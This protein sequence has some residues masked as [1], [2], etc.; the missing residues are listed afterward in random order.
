MAAVG[1]AYIER[2][3]IAHVI[4]YMRKDLAFDTASLGY[5][6]S[7]FGW[8]YVVA[9]PLS[10][11]I[12]TRVGHR[13]VL[14]VSALIWC[15]PGDI[16][17]RPAMVAHV[18]GYLNAIAN[19]G[20]IISPVAVGYVLVQPGGHAHALISMGVASVPAIISFSIAYSIL[21]VHTISRA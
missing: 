10:G 13:R 5:V 12:V 18:S 21:K 19:L 15:V 20:T 8:G 4:P 16:S 6:L 11:F 14:A 9:L 1:I 7:A 3:S 2:T 17:A